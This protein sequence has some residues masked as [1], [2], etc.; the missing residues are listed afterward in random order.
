MDGCATGRNCVT[1][2]VDGSMTDRSPVRFHE[3]FTYYFADQD[4]IVVAFENANSIYFNEFLAKPYSPSTWSCGAPPLGILLGL[5]G[6][7]ATDCYVS[8]QCPGLPTV[9]PSNDTLTEFGVYVTAA[10]TAPKRITASAHA[11]V[12]G[13]PGLDQGKRIAWDLT[14]DVCEQGSGLGSC[15]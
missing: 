1:T 10:S 7:V 5:F 8:T 9:L 15:P 12:I 11:T 3:A 4:G 13:G 14:V 2:W 6:G